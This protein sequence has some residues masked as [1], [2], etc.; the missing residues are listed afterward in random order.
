MAQREVEVVFL[1][2]DLA[3]YT[4][5]TEAHGGGAAAKVVTRFFELVHRALTPGARLL[6]RVGDEALI[7]ADAAVDAVQTAV[8]IREA[9]DVEASFPGV[10]IGIH[11]GMVLEQ[12]GRY[13][14]S[15]LNVTARVAAHARTGQLL[16]TEPIVAALPKELEVAWR[17]L[18]P[19]HLRNIPQPMPIYEILARARTGERRDI[20]PVCRMQV[21]PESAPARLRYGANTLSFC[22]LDCV[23]A[24]VTSPDAYLGAGGRTG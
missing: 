23:K 16:C 20:D 4:A 1:I 11:G 8:R 10:R 12:D 14:G 6:E 9:S 19:V 15:A 17:T 22:S 21:D 24:F 2:A 18:G 3:G 13:F 7:V 5:L